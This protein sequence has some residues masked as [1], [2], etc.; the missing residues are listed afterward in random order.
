MDYICQYWSVIILDST[1]IITGMIDLVAKMLTLSDADEQH[2]VYNHQ[3]EG[4]LADDILRWLLRENVL[5]IMVV[6]GNECV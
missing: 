5:I 4:M 6:T 1:D 2:K 3:L